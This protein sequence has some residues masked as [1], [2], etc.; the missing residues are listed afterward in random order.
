LDASMMGARW[1]ILVG[2]AGGAGREHE[3]GGWPPA[4]V[5]YVVVGGGRWCKVVVGGRRW[6]VVIGGGRQW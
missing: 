6:Y 3:V 2:I 1:F 4:F 5:W